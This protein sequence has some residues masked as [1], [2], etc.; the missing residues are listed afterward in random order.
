MPSTS[1]EIDFS[2]P[3]TTLFGHNLQAW[4]HLRSVLA[5]EV[6]RGRCLQSAQSMQATALDG[7]YCGPLLVVRCWAAVSSVEEASSAVAAS[8]AARSPLV[9]R[10][11][12]IKPS[13][14]PVVYGW[15]GLGVR[16]EGR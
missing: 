13:L 10:R 6:F 14:L 1:I 11:R 9:G 2:A 8:A 16:G 12:P 15:M 5:V 7:M 4:A 3:T